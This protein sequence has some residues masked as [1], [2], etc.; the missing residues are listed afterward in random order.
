[1]Q[2]PNI[3]RMLRA[4]LDLVAQSKIIAVNFLRFLILALLDQKSTQGVPRWVHPRPWLVVR[5]CIVAPNTL[6]EVDECLSVI[7]R[8]IFSPP[9]HHPLPHRQYLARII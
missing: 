9:V 3:V 5:Q 2:C 1:M 7:A 4:S 6:S 8:V